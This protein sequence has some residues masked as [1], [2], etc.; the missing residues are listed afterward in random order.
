MRRI[1]IVPIDAARFAP[2]G[3][4]LEA[5]DKDPRQDRAAAVVNTR[6][7][8]PANL[9]LVRSEP[10]ATAMPLRRLERHP[11]SSQAF[12][13]LSVSAYVVAVAPDAGGVP[14]EAGIL[15]FLVPGGVG[16]SYHPNAWHAHMVTLDAPGVFAMLVHEDGSDGDCVFAGIAPVELAREG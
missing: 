15:A 2:F 6:P 10:Y 8:V 16:L 1:P 3:S 9:A 4:L 12:L 11:H 14:D 5:P 7:G 13:P